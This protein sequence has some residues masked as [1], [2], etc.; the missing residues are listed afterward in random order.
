MKKQFLEPNKRRSLLNTSASFLKLLL[1]MPLLVSCGV[2]RL[3]HDNHIEKFLFFNIDSEATESLV[4]IVMIIFVFGVYMYFSHGWS[5]SEI[6]RNIYNKRGERIGSVGTGEYEETYTSPETAH[7]ESRIIRSI[8]IAIAF[9][10][11]IASILFRNEYIIGIL[12]TISLVRSVVLPWIKG[13]DF[14]TKLLK[15][16]VPFVIFYSIMFIWCWVVLWS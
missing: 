10:C 3:T 12:V 13:E 4:P 1:F 14:C 15:W 2:T 7:K 8:A 16:Q 6:T 5:R 9:P 11:T